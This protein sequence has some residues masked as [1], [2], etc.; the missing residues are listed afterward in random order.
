MVML[1]PKIDPDQDIWRHINS[2]LTDEEGYY[3]FNGLDP[4]KRYYVQFEYDGQTYLPTDYKRPEY[5]TE[6]WKVTSKATE[7]NG[8]RD[9]FDNRFSE[10]G[11][12]PKNYPS[13]DSL[14]T[15]Q[16]VDGH[17]Q[18]YTK[19]D[20]MGY[21]QDENGKYSKTGTQLIDGYEY[22]ERGLQTK[23]Y[24]YGTIN[25][26]LRSWIEGNKRFPSDDEL[27][28]IYKSVAG[29]EETLKMVQF[30]EDCK[31]QAYTGNLVQGGQKDLYPYYENGMFYINSTPNEVG[32][33]LKSVTIK[34]IK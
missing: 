23:E 27:V 29:D 32:R 31:I 3:Q 34:V 2:T 1:D 28:S 7:D 21:E 10:I 5:N 26:A 18:S 24:T 8:D 33:V 4:M 22:D 30:V 16:L 6:E 12:A 25:E 19:L 13:T 17:N 20:L 14:S 11:A 9:A 15:G